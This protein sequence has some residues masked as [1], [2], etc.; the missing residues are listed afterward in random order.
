MNDLLMDI[1]YALRVLRKSPAFT[2]V[3]TL[4]LML[5]IVL[6]LRTLLV[7]LV[8]ALLKR[9]SQRQRSRGGQAPPPIA[10]WTMSTIFP[11]DEVSREKL[12]TKN[13]ERR[14]ITERGKRVRM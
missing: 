5:G 1:R 12:R 3:A 7:G 8:C 9:A 6:F 13:E 14:G 10:T 11:R 4:T 2:L